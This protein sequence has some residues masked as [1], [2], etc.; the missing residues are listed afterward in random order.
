MHDTIRVLI[1]IDESVGVGQ[2]PGNGAWRDIGQ[3]GAAAVCVYPQGAMK[4]DGAT[5]VAR[6]R[7]RIDCP[8]YR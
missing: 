5:G 7:P 4:S 8:T 6:A 3:A 2:E 1:T